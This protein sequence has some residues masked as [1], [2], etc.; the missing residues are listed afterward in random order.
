[1]V[2]RKPLTLTQVKELK[3]RDEV[4]SID[5]FDSSGAAKRWRVNGKVQ[6]WKTRPT[7]FRVPLKYGLCGL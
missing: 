4:Y 2:E 6:L 3:Y 5:E 1:M 7:D